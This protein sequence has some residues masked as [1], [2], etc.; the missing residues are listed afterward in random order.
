MG[1]Q[2]TDAGE[3]FWQFGGGEWAP[4]QNLALAF[5][6]R[7]IGVVIFTNSANGEE[8]FEYFSQAATRHERPL[9]INKGL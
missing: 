5:R 4:F 6:E 2:Q 1:I 9:L 3:C 7:G 8:V